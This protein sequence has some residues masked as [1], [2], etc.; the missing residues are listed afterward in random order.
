VDCIKGRH[1]DGDVRRGCEL[2]LFLPLKVGNLDCTFCLDCVQACPHD[3]I[4][5]AL[6]VPGAE[7]SDARR[8][9]G[10]G[11]LGRRWDIAALAV[12]FTFSGMLNAFAMVGPVYG[13]ERWLSAAL[14]ARS[15]APALAAL[16]A[17]A[18]CVI[19]AVLLSVAAGSTRLLVN[20]ASGSFGRTAMRY[21]YALVPFGVGVWVAHYEF[22]L[23]TGAL[24]ILPVAQSAALDVVGFPI[25]GGPL[26]RLVGLSPGSVFPVQLGFVLLGALGSLAVAYRISQRDYPERPGLAMVPWALLTVMLTLTVVWILSLPME[27]RAVGLFG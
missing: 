11:R 4:A 18:L 25:L 20:D 16:F 17:I 19:P 23:L 26:W 22:H 3:N 7:L 1:H 15:E 9:S 8:R 21:A 12:V 14:G 2:G 24:T 27:M 6:R 5:L 10:V 13:V